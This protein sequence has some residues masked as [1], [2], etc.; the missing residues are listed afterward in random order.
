MKRSLANG[1][2]PTALLVVA[3]ALSLAA[4]ADVS[5]GAVVLH[6]GSRVE[7]VESTDRRAVT[8]WLDS[9]TRMAREMRGQ[10]MAV[11]PS[12]TNLPIVTQTAVSSRVGSGLMA[13]SP[14]AFGRWNHVDLPP[15]FIL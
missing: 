6:A 14:V 10:A 7:S 2:P 5:L 11:L 4:S 8:Q 1:I 9:L 12:G 3:V 13:F 15:P